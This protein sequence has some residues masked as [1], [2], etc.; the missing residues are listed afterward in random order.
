M[1]STQKDNYTL[2]TYASNQFSEFIAELKQDLKQF[3]DQNLVVDVEKQNKITE[4][5]L[6]T[7]LELSNVQYRHKKSFIILNSNIDIDT[8]SEE[9]RVVP[10]LQEAED[11][12][13]ME[14][15]ERDLGF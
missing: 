6:S 13:Q 10:T 5:E 8:I 7:L 2:I 12:I 3:S 4:E 9:L 11:M 14:D 15:I 1:E